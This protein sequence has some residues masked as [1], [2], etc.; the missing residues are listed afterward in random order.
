ME[1]RRALGRYYK[2]TAPVPKEATDDAVPKLNIIVKGDVAG[3]VEAILDVFGTYGSDDKC[4]LSVVHYGVGPV[5]ET[6]LQMAE[7]FDGKTRYVATSNDPTCLYPPP[8][9]ITS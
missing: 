6:D 8:R 7:M 2:L 4:Q 9:V 3:S 1:K 5:T